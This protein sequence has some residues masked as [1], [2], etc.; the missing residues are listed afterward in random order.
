MK[1]LTTCACALVLS[2]G[3]AAC[4]KKPATPPAPAPVSVSQ[5][6]LGK[7]IGADKRVTAA[8]ESFAKNDTIYAS[9]DTQGSGNASLKAKWTFVKGDKTALVNESTQD[10]VAQGP[11]V[12]EFHISKPDGWPVGNYQVEIFLGDK[13]AGSKSYTVK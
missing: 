11:A 13:S 1:R 8:T 6:T 3:L 10:I 5:V 4:N 9:V 12:S 7:A 2:T